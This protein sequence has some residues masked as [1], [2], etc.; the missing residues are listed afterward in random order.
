VEVLVAVAAADRCHGAH[1]EVVGIGADGMDRLLEGEF[2]SASR[3]NASMHSADGDDCGSGLF[4]WA[5]VRE[6]ARCSIASA[7]TKGLPSITQV[8]ISSVCSFPHHVHFF[9]GASLSPNFGEARQSSSQQLMASGR[10]EAAGFMS[11]ANRQS[12]AS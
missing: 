12:E 8:V 7:L 5:G 3:D 6:A 11:A 9:I 1:P 2:D 4:C 10:A